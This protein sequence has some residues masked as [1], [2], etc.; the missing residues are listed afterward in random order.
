[1]SGVKQQVIKM[2]ETMSDEITIDDIMAELYF[3][4]Q[5]D[6]GLK[7]L[8]EDKGIPHEEA[9]ERLSQWLSR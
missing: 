1:M 7:E 2:I 3:K 8:D 6:A 9:K 5:V 4:M